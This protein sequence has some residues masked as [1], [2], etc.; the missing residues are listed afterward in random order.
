LP[1]VVEH[2]GGGGCARPR[3]RHTVILEQARDRRIGVRH[4][5]RGRAVKFRE[6]PG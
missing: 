1:L 4:G 2:G 3:G 6:E 5:L